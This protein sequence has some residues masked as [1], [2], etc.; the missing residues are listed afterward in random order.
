ML[1]ISEL[2]F[3]FFSILNLLEKIVEYKDYNFTNLTKKRWFEYLI[4]SLEQYKN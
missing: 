1:N 3:K 4:S 2:D